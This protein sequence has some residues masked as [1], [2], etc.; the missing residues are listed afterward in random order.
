MEGFSF[1]ND[2]ADSNATGTGNSN[3]AKEIK[4]KKILHKRSST[5][6]TTE[7]VKN[8]LKHLKKV[9]MYWLLGLTENC[10]Q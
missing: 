7:V 10:P 4:W 1:A 9:T 2:K 8:H 6:V 3:V 5:K